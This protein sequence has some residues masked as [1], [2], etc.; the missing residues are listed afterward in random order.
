MNILNL[1]QEKEDGNS[2][3]FSVKEGSIS[4][5]NYNL[6]YRSDTELVLKNLSFEIEAKQQIGVVGRT[7]AGKSTISLAL[8]RIVEGYS[9]KI[10]IDGIDISTINLNE[11]RN[12]MAMISQDPSLFTGT[13]RFNLDP[14]HKW[15]EAHIMEVVNNCSLTDIVNRDS[16]GLEQVIEEGGKN[17]SAGEKQL[18]CISRAV[19][20]KAKIIVM[21]EATA[22]IDVKTE[23]WIQRAISTY[24]KGLTVIK[25]AHR[26][27]TVMQWDKVLVLENGRV[28][29][30]DDP[31]VLIKNPESQFASI[32]R[33]G[34]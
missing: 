23:G 33:S 29:E 27:S 14:D 18:V 32:V 16:L 21:D 15:S 5:Q 9:G 25:I 4:F 10:L 13:L 26:I 8:W 20:K 3:K 19:L 34:L 28:I 12:N 6:K 30:F 7:G 24:F 17:L 1:P 2:N 11:L 31:Q 22:N